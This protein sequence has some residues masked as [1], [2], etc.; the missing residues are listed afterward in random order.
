MA[1]RWIGVGQ[2][3]PAVPMPASMSA[4]RPRPSNEE[5][6]TVITTSELRRTEALRENQEGSWLERSLSSAPVSLC[7]SRISLTL[8]KVQSTYFLAL[9]QNDRVASLYGRTH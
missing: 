2:E 3:Y 5:T 4:D 9:V 1:F 6:V 7:L 8:V